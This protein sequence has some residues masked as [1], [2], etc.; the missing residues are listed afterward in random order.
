MQHRLRD[1]RELR[2]WSRIDRDSPGLIC[3]CAN[4]C[5]DTTN[6]C[7][8]SQFTD[9][10]SSSLG[11][12]TSANCPGSTGLFSV[13]GGFLS[14]AFAGA[15]YTGASGAYTQAITIPTLNGLCISV[16]AKIYAIAGKTVGTTGVTIGGVSAMVGRYA[17]P[18][19]TQYLT[20]NDTTAAGCQ[21]VATNH[22]Y[23]TANAN[24]VDGDC[25]C[26]VLQ[27]TSSGAGT[28]SIK[29]YVNGVLKDTFS[30]VAKT[31]TA[32]GTINVG[33][34]DTNGGQ[35]DNLCIATS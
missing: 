24:F 28:Y 25:L 27:D 3:C 9:S 32:G 30:G 31:L 4:I 26:L 6:A 10:F 14:E 2:D 33:V 5:C 11:G 7:A 18:A 15:P 8:A 19:L 29:S 35:W 20:S 22:T 16:S 34:T 1:Y 23:G 17:S 13:G 12:Y 21:K